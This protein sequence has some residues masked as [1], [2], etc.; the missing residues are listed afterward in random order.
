MA[1]GDP[2]AEEV[3]G[4]AGCGRLEVVGDVLLELVRQYFVAEGEQIINVNWYN[5]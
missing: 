5:E 2:N 1:S 3:M 4:V